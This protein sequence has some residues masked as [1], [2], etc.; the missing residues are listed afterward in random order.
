[1]QLAGEMESVF[2]TLPEGQIE[3]DCN[4]HLS[5]RIY[6]GPE[7]VLA[8]TIEDRSKTERRRS[9]LVRNWQDQPSSERQQDDAFRKSFVV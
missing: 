6:E 3:V 2:E 8:Q 4:P 5:T 9:D 7:V 1:M